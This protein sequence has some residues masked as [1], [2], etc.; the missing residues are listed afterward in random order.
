VFILIAAMGLTLTAI[1]QGPWRIVGILLGLGGIWLAVRGW[2]TGIVLDDDRLRVV[3]FFS[4]RTLAKSEVHSIARF[5]A[6]DYVT[7]R[8][9]AEVLVTAFAGATDGVLHRRQQEV[10]A[11][12]A[13]WLR[14]DD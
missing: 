14:R 12:V 9:N 8:G 11:A 3:G 10:K 6:I 13:E 4:S 7:D 5:P 2:S 1:L